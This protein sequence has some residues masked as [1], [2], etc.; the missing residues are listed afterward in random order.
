[1]T[2]HLFCAEVNF[3]SLTVRSQDGSEGVGRPLEAPGVEQQGAACHAARAEPS[4]K[5]TLQVTHVA[6]D[7]RKPLET[8]ERNRLR[9]CAMKR[10]F[11]AQNI[12][13]A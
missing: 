5:V 13:L 1:M 9:L 8:R 2:F 6:E 7:A 4:L 3:R 11:I 10:R 12:D